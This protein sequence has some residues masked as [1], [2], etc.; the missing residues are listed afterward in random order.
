MT[1]KLKITIIIDRTDSGG[2]RKGLGQGRII[3]L[4]IR[5]GAGS[6]SRNVSAGG[7][8]VGATL[9]RVPPGGTKGKG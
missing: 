1:K 6:R 9:S 7:R 5:H 4:V 3:I 8:G 2:G